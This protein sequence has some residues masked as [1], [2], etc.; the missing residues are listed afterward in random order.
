MFRNVSTMQAR[1]CHFHLRI[2]HIQRLLMKNHIHEK[3]IIF[4]SMTSRAKTIEP[5]SNLIEKR[6][7]DIQR[8]PD[9]LSDFSL[10]IILWEI[11][12][13]VCEKIV[14]FQTDLWWPLVT[15]LKIDLT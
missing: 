11:I 5:S 12:A 1:W 15:S 6:N 14:I 9:C 8:A 2:S 3:T 13:L 4:Y 7:R 10:A